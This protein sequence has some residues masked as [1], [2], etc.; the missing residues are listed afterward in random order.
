MNICPITIT[1]A[2]AYVTRHHRHHRAPVSGLFA[3]ACEADGQIVGVAI[4]GRP[5]AR[6]LQDGYTAEITRLCTDGTKNACSMLY[7]ASW[8]A[9]RALGY[10][11]LITYILDTEPGTSLRAA[12]WKMVAH[13]KGGTWN[14]PSRPRVDMHPNKAS[15]GGKHHDN[16]PSPSRSYTPRSC[17]DC[18]ATSMR[19]ITAGMGLGFFLTLGAGWVGW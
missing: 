2:R 11:R 4:V 15:S 12:G 10:R 8:R 13:T 9:A 19:R 1:E 6:G 16:H 3:V 7:A 17:P 18:V 14:R 5:V